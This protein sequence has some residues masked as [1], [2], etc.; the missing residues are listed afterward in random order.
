MGSGEK[1]SSSSPPL[2]SIISST[3]SASPL[4]LL[5]RAPRRRQC[6]AL[7]SAAGTAAHRRAAR[8]GRNQPH[9]PPLATPGSPLWAQVGRRS[10]PGECCAGAASPDGCGFQC[11]RCS[12]LCYIRFLAS[13]RKSQVLSLDVSV[14]LSVDS[15]SVDPCSALYFF[16]PELAWFWYGNLK[17]SPLSPLVPYASSPLISFPL[18][19]DSFC[20]CIR[21]VFCQK[22][23]QH[24]SMHCAAVV[25]FSVYISD[26]CV[27]MVLLYLF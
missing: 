7:R 17:K 6:T 23:S 21:F 24:V 22:K 10:D 26:K 13:P 27:T 25:I 5:T 8:R 3:L 19:M 2:L 4:S 11:L 14:H 12:P 1:I 9:L 20:L 16:L 15:A 18:C